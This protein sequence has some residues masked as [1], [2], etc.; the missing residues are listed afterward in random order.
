VMVVLPLEEPISLGWDTGLVEDLFL[1]RLTSTD[2]FVI[3]ADRSVSAIDQE[4]K[5][6]FSGYTSDP[7]EGV[8]RPDADIVTSLL[9]G[10]WNDEI[11]LYARVWVARDGSALLAM[12]RPITAATYDQDVTALADELIFILSTYTGDTAVT[13][14]RIMLS[15]G[16][17]EE[18]ESIM[19][20]RWL[21]EG[22]SPELRADLDNLRRERIQ[23]MDLQLDTALKENHLDYAL[24]IFNDLYRLDPFSENLKAYADRLRALIIKQNE[25]TSSSLFNEALKA[26]SKSNINQGNRFSYSLATGYIQADMA[27][28]LDELLFSQNEAISNVFID[29]AEFMI[30]DSKLQE[31]AGESIQSSDRAL[32]AAAQSVIY[33]SES[34]KALRILEKAGDA[35]LNA[36]RKYERTFSDQPRWKDAVQ[37]PRFTYSIAYTIAPYLPPPSLSSID[38]GSV[39][40]V[41]VG[42]GLNFPYKASW[43]FTLLPAISYEWGTESGTAGSYSWSGQNN[44]F[45]MTLEGGV[46]YGLRYFHIEAGPAFR[47]GFGS[48]ETHWSS[49]DSDNS[50]VFSYAI[51]AFLDVT[52]YPFPGI[53]LGLKFRATGTRPDSYP[54]YFH[55]EIIF[56]TVIDIEGF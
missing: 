13:S 8:S 55:P 20:A 56:R 4:L 50:F 16:Y 24:L 51:G 3:R 1:A 30:H 28:Y 52:A 22:A 47:A 46:H 48:Q 39:Q 29:E 19:Q 12:M 40:G 11:R 2:H 53:G 27:A 18:A 35:N 17:F 14:S 41:E 31:D 9:I 34:E 23:R 37:T 25:E 33:N 54:W 21:S 38:E 6:G 10:K 5:L 26:Y 7:I 49:G 15:K 32:T 45:W 42:I 36:V 44:T 43:A